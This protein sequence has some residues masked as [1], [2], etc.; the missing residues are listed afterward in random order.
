MTALKLAALA[1]LGLFSISSSAQAKIEE[2]RITDFANHI[3]LADPQVSPDQRRVAYVRTFANE[4]L[5]HQFEIVLEDL[6][7]A[8]RSRLTAPNQYAHTPRWVSS[9]ELS[10]LALTKGSGHQVFLLNVDSAELTQVT[11]HA[12]SVQ[13]YTWSPD[14]TQ[15]AYASR[16]KQEPSRVRAFPVTKSSISPPREPQS[17][18]L[19]TVATN[20]DRKLS[21]ATPLVDRWSRISWSPDASMLLYMRKNPEHFDEY[22]NHMVE[23]EFATGEE[24]KLGNGAYPQ[25]SP[26]GDRVLFLARETPD[27]PVG[28]RKAYT[29]DTVTG[30]VQRV[31][32]KLDRETLGRFTTDGRVL[33]N[34]PELDAQKLWLADASETMEL[35]LQG[36]EPIWPL[37]ASFVGSTLAFVGATATS[38]QELYVFDGKGIRRVT[39]ENAALTSSRKRGTPKTLQWK[40][41]DGMDISGIALFPPGFQKNVRYPLVVSPHGGPHTTSTVAGVANNLV[42]Q[43]MSSKGWIVL[44]PN[45]RGSTNQGRDF[46]MVRAGNANYDKEVVA[47][48]MSGIDALEKQCE[49]VDTRRKAIL[50][51]SY[52][53][54]VAAWATALHPREWV[55]SVVGNAGLD[56]VDMY[57]RSDRGAGFSTKYGGPPWKAELSDAY[58]SASPIYAA[59]AIQT[60]T[61]VVSTLRDPRVPVIQ[62]F[63]YWKAL[64][65]SGTEVEFIAYDMSGHG[66]PDLPNSMDYFQR[67]IEWIGLRFDRAKNAAIGTH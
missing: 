36:V 61:L 62:S 17:L 11:H 54:T 58:R 60:P 14:N 67:A 29:L 45:F 20:E 22:S 49:C 55:A 65:D 12:N 19:L 39:N 26:K 40:S 6:V 47:D 34:G 2:F 41:A 44:C 24:R 21:G 33:L 46:H 4:D 13:G 32:A 42:N 50:G 23:F 51:T 16:P 5:R 9:S 52:G 66:P 7:S 59:E 64:E 27:Y 57:A 3:S 56:D 48:V 28:P 25:Y 1:T 43:T 30:K 63:K 53:G 15:L 31:A 8:E 18:H 37:Q 35:D 38:S 10:I